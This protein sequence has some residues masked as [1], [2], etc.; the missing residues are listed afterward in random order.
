MPSKQ[1]RRR[2]VDR[3]RNPASVTVPLVDTTINLPDRAAVAWYAGL[4]VMAA[5]ELVEWPFALAVAG[6]HFLANHAQRR[7]VQELVEGL[8]AGI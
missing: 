1:T 7:D 4:G 6:T 3:L 2:N 8:E 5:L